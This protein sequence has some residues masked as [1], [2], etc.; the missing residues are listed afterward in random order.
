MQQE[1]LAFSRVY[2]ESERL[3]C[4]L[5]SAGGEEVLL[6][7]RI[8]EGSRMFLCAAEVLLFSRFYGESGMF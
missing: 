7:S 4:L 6:F 1:V 5:D 2:G 3:Q 8:S